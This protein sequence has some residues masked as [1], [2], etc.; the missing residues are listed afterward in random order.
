MLY[1]LLRRVYKT[2]IST[3][4]IQPNGEIVPYFWE[5]FFWLFSGAD[6]AITTIVPP[7]GR[8]PS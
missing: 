7:E 4:A 3:V 5:L 6:T 1:Y 2:A 8:K